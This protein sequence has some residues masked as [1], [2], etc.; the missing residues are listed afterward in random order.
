MR[1]QSL[2]QLASKR[3]EGGRLTPYEPSFIPVTKKDQNVA[4]TLHMLMRGE[5]HFCSASTAVL[6]GESTALSGFFPV[7][8]EVGRACISKLELLG[9][10]KIVCEAMMLI[11]EV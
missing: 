6:G 1:D 4:K 2:L 11:F 10:P 3:S 5:S 7:R 9:S 8:L